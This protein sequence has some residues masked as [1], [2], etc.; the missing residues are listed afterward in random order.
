M[1]REV[2]E[3]DADLLMIGHVCGSQRSADLRLLY[4]AESWETR[5]KR[6]LVAAGRHNRA[7]RSVLDARDAIP[8]LREAEGR[9]LARGVPRP[10]KK[11]AS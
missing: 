4:P 6:L 1:P 7:A 2:P 11:G 5:E 8:E 9:A 10:P 3:A